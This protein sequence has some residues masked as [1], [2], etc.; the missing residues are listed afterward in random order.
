METI[1]KIIIFFFTII[2][3]FEYVVQMLC[4]SFATVIL[5]GR[6]ITKNK[7]QI[8]VIVI[9]VIVL[10]CLFVFLNLF[11]TILASFWKFIQLGYIYTFFSGVI[12][13]ALFR[14]KLVI[15][16]RILMSCVVISLAV[17]LGVLG[18][19]LGHYIARFIPSF[20]VGIAKIVS[21][22]VIAL[23]AVI[24]NKYSITA[25]EITWPHLALNMIIVT[26][27]ISLI[28]G[29]QALNIDRDFHLAAIR[30]FEKYFVFLLIGLL[31]INVAAYFITYYL[32]V[33][34]AKDISLQTI[35]MKEQSVQQQLM[36]SEK[37]LNELCH[38]KHDLKNQ[39]AYMSVLLK[40][41]KFDELEAFFDEVTGSF[42]KKLFASVDSGNTVIDS[43][44]NLEI[45]KATTAGV[46]V[47]ARISIPPELPFSK[48]SLL[49]LIAN[50]V[51]NAIEEVSKCG[52]EGAA[53]K[54]VLTVNGDYLLFNV[55]NETDREDEE[56]ILPIKTTSKAKDYMRG[57]GTA[58]INNIIKK[59][60]GFY[61]CYVL[62]K[63][64]IFE[65][66]LNM[67]Y[68]SGGGNK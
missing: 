60:D 50:A 53:I 15:K 36:V 7:K 43:I 65:S 42:S 33:E 9:E 37:R 67:Q 49:S 2:F 55:E 63:K 48:K 24:F 5:L 32:C 46:N 17:L 6:R 68:K 4:I 54:I 39:Y 34:K 18:T 56:F 52:K 66:C 13:Y 40:G 10:T 35:K 22:L 51:D 20:N 44:L 28:I 1:K 25:Y 45:S 30:F 19:S 38:I 47:D 64:F 31:I 61:K 23:C 62:N 29:Y 14:S 57:N 11:Y 12:L 3:D 21:Y 27:T 16:A 59:Y 58:I 8:L 26:I 41:K